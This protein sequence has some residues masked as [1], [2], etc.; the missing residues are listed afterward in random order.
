MIF[1][2]GASSLVLF[3]VEKRI[4]ARRV[5]SLQQAT[6]PLCKLRLNNFNANTNSDAT[7]ANRGNR[8]SRVQDP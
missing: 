4:Y 1:L 5:Q 7:T 8:L 2:F 3:F 6:H